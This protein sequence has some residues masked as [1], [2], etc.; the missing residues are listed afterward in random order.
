MIGLRMLVA[1]VAAAALV[2]LGGAASA[3]AGST[4]VTSGIAGAATAG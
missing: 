4:N 3:G 1:S 2:V